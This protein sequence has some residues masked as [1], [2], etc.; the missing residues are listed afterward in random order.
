MSSKCALY[1]RRPRDAPPF[2]QSDRL[3]DML[4][5]NSD[6]EKNALRTILLLDVICRVALA[7]PKVPQQCGLTHKD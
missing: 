4:L 5:D 7:G 6:T 2:D 1:R 3:R